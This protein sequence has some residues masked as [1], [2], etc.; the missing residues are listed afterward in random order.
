MLD[1]NFHEEAKR[2]ISDLQSLRSQEDIRL[3]EEISSKLILRGE[4]LFV[5]I[6]C[7]IKELELLQSIRALAQ[8]GIPDKCMF[9]VFVNGGEQIDPSLFT[10][11]AN[12]RLKEL[13][14]VKESFPEL[15]LIAVTHQFKGKPTISRIRGILTDAVTRSC[16]DH[17]SDD[18]IIVSNDAD[19][20]A[21]AP[22]YLLRIREAFAQDTS[23]DY[24]SGDINW[25][26]LD[27]R[28]LPRY[29]PA[30]PLPELFLKD[31]LGHASD[32]IYRQYSPVYTTGCNSAFRLSTICSI[33]GYD[34]KF[35][36]SF[37]VEIGAVLSKF[38]T[39]SE[40]ATPGQFARFIPEC[41]LVANPRRNVYAQLNDIPYGLQFDL[42]FGTVYGSDIDLEDGINTYLQNDEFIQMKDLLN[43]DE[44]KNKIYSRMTKTFLRWLDGE[45]TDWK[46]TLAETVAPKVGLKIADIQ[47]NGEMVE[48]IEFDWQECTLDKAME[49]WAKMVDVELK[50]R[51][52]NSCR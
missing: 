20:L 42:T 31:V 9:V 16:L 38:A 45:P 26:G 46:R 49:A 19:A 2:F 36:P 41:L 3:I 47:A 43:F 51:E 29:S 48:I 5:L 44:C 4:E 40:K 14:Q 50:M 21:Y 34:Y 35:D 13:D 32:D 1:S 37:D 11:L 18:P 8:A 27:G 22:G 28:G 33:D 30:E 23:I 25:S 7:Y 52:P 17:N 6:P 39:I 12:S 24:I 10:E 15:N